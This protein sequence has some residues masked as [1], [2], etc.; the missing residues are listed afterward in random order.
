MKEHSLRA[1]F[2]FFQ[3]GNNQ[4]TIY[5][6]SAA[7]TQKPQCVIDTIIDFYTYKNTNVHR[8]SHSL[9]QRTT[10]EF[11]QART[12]VKDFIGAT[13]SAEIIFTKGATESINL[14]AKA[15]ADTDIPNGKRILISATEHHAN[16]VPWQQ[17]AR[18]KQ[19]EIDVI[20]VDSAG[21]WLIEEGLSLLTE[22]TCIVALG[23]VSN[24]LGTINPIK[25]FLDKANSVNALTLVDAAQGIAHLAIDVQRLNCD[26]LVFSGHKAYA[27]TGIGVLYGKKAKLEVLPVFLTG[28]EMIQKVDY[29]TASFQAAPFKFEAG[30]PN[31]EG[32]LT[33]KQALE[34]INTHRKQIDHHERQ[35]TSY[36]LAKLALVKGI[37]V[38]GQGE[39][40]STVSF[41]VNGYNSHDLGTLLNEQGVAMRVGHHCAMPLMKTLGVAGTLRISLACYNEKYEIDK[42][43]VALQVAINKIAPDNSPIEHDEKVNQQNTENMPLAEAVQ[44]AKGWDSVYRQIM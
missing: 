16:L 11:E 13:H 39:R 21:N 30:T 28:G 23:M 27:S 4:Q 22:A 26:F 32:V 18:Q 20:P 33:L 14:V 5:F 6:D 29:Q 24:A 36:L 44:S 3:H 19:L 2:P 9:A 37:V 15:L 1:Q 43:M 41:S 10:N 40:I 12:Y 8:A 17:L 35:L 34:F 38:Y 31:V 42:A 7:T 25:I